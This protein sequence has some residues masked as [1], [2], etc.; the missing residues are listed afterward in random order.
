[1]Y[2]WNR[3]RRRWGTW[4]QQAWGGQP[5]C[6]STPE[7]LGREMVR[8]AGIQPGMRVL[9]PEAGDGALA[10]I[11][12]ATCPEAWLDVI[13]IDPALQALLHQQGY[14]VAGQD[15]LDYQ[16]GPVYG[17][18]VMNPPFRGRQDIWH[19]LTC[20]DFVAPGGRLVTIASAESVT[21]TSTRAE[22]FRAW[23]RERQAWVQRLPGGPNGIFMQS[24]R[25]TQ[26]ET[27]LIVLQKPA[28]AS[29]AAA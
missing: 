28:A 25:P 3:P 2:H 15:A 11:V 8:L 26:V 9:E 12:R 20:F 19:I 7:P 17:A 4:Q 24:A 13:E 29:A 16:A 5:R 1:M 6:Y 18:V 14:H 21:G 22:A 10:R 23:L 27:Y